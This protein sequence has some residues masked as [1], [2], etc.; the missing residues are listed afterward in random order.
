[1]ANKFAR[2][3]KH[4][5]SSQFDEKID[6]IIEQPTNNTQ[7]LMTITPSVETEVATEIT[8][9]DF[10][11][12]ETGD[13]GENT[14]GLFL[15]DGTILTI[16][17]PGDTSYV[18]GPM[19]SMWYAWGNFTRI[20]YIRQSDRKMVNLASISGELGD[21]DGTADD[22]TSYGQLTLAQ[23]DWF[24]T[25]TKKDGANNDTPN[26][27]AFYPGPPSNTP[28]EY[29]RYYCV[30]T[31]T[32]KD[33]PG[34]NKSVTS[35]PGQGP[36]DATTQFS[37]MLNQL[38]NKA[39][40]KSKD[41][42]DAALE[43][44]KD[45]INKAKDLVKDIYDE[46]DEFTD[47]V[48]ALEYSKNIAESILDNK[49]IDKSDTITQEEK[50]KLL[51][52]L[53]LD[54][55]K[56][57]DG[58]PTPYADDN[59]ITDENGNVRPRAEWPKDK[60]G[61]EIFL[62]KGDPGYEEYKKGIDKWNED[63]QHSNNTG[64]V[65]N[66]SD[67]E[68]GAG[69]NNPLAAAGQAQTQIVFPEDGSEPYFKYTDHAYLNN[70]SMDEGEVPDIGK[71]ILSKVVT[72]MSDRLHR[73]QGKVGA[74]THTDSDAPNTGEMK[75]YPPNIRGDVK[76]EFTVPYSQL[77]SHIQN[78]VDQQKNNQSSKKKSGSTQIATIPSGPNSP[79]PSPGWTPRPGSSF[80]PGATWNPP[81][82][83]GGTG[84]YGTTIK[85]AQNKKKKKN[86][87]LAANYEPQSQVLSEGRKWLREIRKPVDVPELP[88]KLK[89]KPRVRKKEGYKVVGEG[90][91]KDQVA[92][93]E[94][95]STRDNRMW[96][97]YEMEQNKRT[98]QEKKNQVL[99]KI[100]EGDHQWNYMIANENWRTSEQMKKF[101]GTHDDLYTYYHSGKKHK[102]VRKEGLEKDFLLFVE[103]ED[104]IKDTI[105]QSELNDL[106]AYERDQEDFKGHYLYETEQKERE[107]NFDKVNKIKKVIGDVKRGELA[108]EYPKDPPPKTIDGWHPKL[109]KNYKHDKLDP[110]SAEAMPATGDPEI[111]A[112]IE[113]A[114]DKKAKARKTKVLAGKTEQFSNWRDELTDA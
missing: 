24:R 29:G 73:P 58:K 83:G 22:F 30:I 50:T 6:A 95:S 77:P 70:K 17:P 35:A 56:I 113:K 53:N 48:P 13:D 41:L 62:K 93:P 81:K 2:A 87:T 27:R 21:W 99:E 15:S 34:P 32:P 59:I 64:P 100:G 109:G 31:G 23:A 9:L 5:K 68:L 28:D 1:M 45:A 55:L 66:Q 75:D 88:T 8:Y 63:H 60:D 104:G 79:L 19:S 3:L 72:H 52:N 38:F 65:T 46:I 36:E 12:G 10:A 57:S 39:K 54:N 101:Y 20:G 71:D 47:Q 84:T 37:G 92:P 107:I 98:S 43:G 26:Y 105:L 61:K 82:P 67:E 90:L 96:R 91:M 80:R 112:N 69:Y 42:L 85:L 97:K 44:G 76:K 51:N 89:V 74:Y 86:G 18:L 102:I 108:P 111:D 40:K 49:P 114:T 94:F 110:Q 7:N 33:F 14:S 106:I 103:D 11:T 78:Y 25:T 16:E 4:L